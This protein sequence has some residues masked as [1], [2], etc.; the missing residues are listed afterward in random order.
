[1]PDLKGMKLDGFQ[2]TDIETS[3]IPYK[4]S[5]QEELR[6]KRLVER[7]EEKPNDENKVVW[8]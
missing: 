2:R 4:N 5:K 8:V 6:Q 1:M 3:K 7:K